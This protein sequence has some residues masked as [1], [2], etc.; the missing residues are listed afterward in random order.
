MVKAVRTAAMRLG[1][2][3]SMRIVAEP[4]GEMKRELS[5]AREGVSLFMSRLGPVPMASRMPRMAR[6]SPLPMAAVSMA[7]L[8]RLAARLVVAAINSI[9]RN[10]L[11]EVVVMKASMD[12]GSEGL[13]AEAMMAAVSRN[14]GRVKGVM[15]MRTERVRTFL[16]LQRMMMALTETPKRR[17]LERSKRSEP[18]GLKKT[19]RRKIVIR[20]IQAM[21]RSRVWAVSLVGLFIGLH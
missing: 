16:A 21:A 7:R 5:P 15:V 20:M 18:T 8:M 19:G 12:R 2:R 11:V 14:K 4:G 9:N 17:R 13:M 3:K 6:T 10:R 1:M